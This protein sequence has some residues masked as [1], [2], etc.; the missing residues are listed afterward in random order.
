MLWLRHFA[1]DHLPESLRAEGA[2]QKPIHFLPLH[3]LTLPTVHT[4]NIHCEINLII[5][6][7]LVSYPSL[8]LVIP[9]HLNMHTTSADRFFVRRLSRT[10]RT[11]G[12][13]HLPFK[14]FKAVCTIKTLPAYPFFHPH[15]HFVPLSKPFLPNTNGPLIT[16][17]PQFYPLEIPKSRFYPSSHHLRQPRP[18]WTPAKWLT[19]KN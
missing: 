15:P 3:R 8:F 5:P 17:P 4:V 16:L 9:S 19:R 18:Q 11:R 12:S 13:P 7:W 6:A 14:S 2:I 1:P 10:I